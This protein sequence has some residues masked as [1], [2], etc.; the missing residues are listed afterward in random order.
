MPFQRPQ[1]RRSDDGRRP[2]CVKR[3]I[4]G[5]NIG[6]IRRDD[7]VMLFQVLRK[8]RQLSLHLHM[9]GI[10]ASR[11]ARVGELTLIHDFCTKLGRRGAIGLGQ[12]NI[13]GMRAV[14]ERPA[15]PFLPDQEL[16]HGIALHLPRRRDMQDIAPT[17]GAAQRGIRCQ[18]IE[19]QRIRSGGL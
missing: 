11:A 5:E 18:R 14:N 4:G 2:P 19:D 12:R 3:Q 6:F 10:R 13:F 16:R 1:P 17:F 9:P 8:D 7:H 15:R